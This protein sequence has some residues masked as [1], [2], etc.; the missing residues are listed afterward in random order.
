WPFT[1]PALLI[2]SMA[3][4]AP[5]NCMSPYCATGPVTGPARAMRTVSAASVEVAAPVKA[6]AR[7]SLER[8]WLVFICA[9]LTHYCWNLLAAVSLRDEHPQTMRQ[10]YRHSVE[11]SSPIC[12]A[13]ID[14][15]DE[16]SATAI[17][18]PFE[19][20]ESP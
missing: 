14:S 11:A 9:P 7:K 4:C 18:S 19:S 10:L 20:S 15:F 17:M 1:P 12:T 5:M 16:G 2:C 8:R 3:I 6:M 13:G